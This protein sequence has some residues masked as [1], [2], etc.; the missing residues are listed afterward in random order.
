MVLQKKKLRPFF[1]GR[2]YTTKDVKMSRGQSKATKEALARIRVIY[3]EI[4]KYLKKLPPT[5]RMTIGDLAQEFATRFQLR[6]N[7]VKPLISFYF[8]VKYDIGDTD[9]FLTR[10]RMGGIQKRK[11]PQVNP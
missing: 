11:V 6:V 2:S 4:D 9:V 10:G 1:D 5:A 8:H 7:D 3:T